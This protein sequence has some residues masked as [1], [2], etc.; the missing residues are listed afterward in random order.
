MTI[1]PELWSD[2]DRYLVD[3]LIASDPALDAALESSAAA[4]L[5]AIQ[6]APNQGKLLYLL[7]RIRSARNILEIGTLGGYS[8]IWLARALP[9]DGRLVT[10]EYDP[11]HA[12]VATANLKRAG[13]EDIVSVRVGPA[14]ESLPKIKAEGLGPF[15]LTFIDANKKNNPDYFQWALDLSASGSIIIVDNVVREGGVLD[16]GTKDE[17]IRGT[18]RVIEMMGKEP[19]VSATAIQTVGSKGYDGFAIA[20]VN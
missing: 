18:R 5:P 1:S 13:F 6:V 14:L 11:K 17:D 7:A 2:V 9:A 4:G 20:V 8:T 19:R 16:S 12:E 3:S 15:D 10:L